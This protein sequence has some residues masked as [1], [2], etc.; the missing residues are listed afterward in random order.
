MQKKTDYVAVG[1]RHL[2][3]YNHMEVFDTV[4]EF[5]RT[6]NRIVIGYRDAGKSERETMRFDIG[7]SSIAVRGVFGM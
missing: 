6:R 5:Y 1:T 4:P 3:A 2:L 7:H